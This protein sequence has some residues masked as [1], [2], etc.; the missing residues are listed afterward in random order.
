MGL[1]LS[2][3]SAACQSWIRRG[4]TRQTPGF[5]RLPARSTACG[6][7]HCSLKWALLQLPWHPGSLIKTCH[8]S[9][10][11]RVFV[12]WHPSTLVGLST[13]DLKGQFGGC[14]ATKALG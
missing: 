1:G 11:K 14:F 9:L 10:D 2:V 4:D 6:H 7:R 3:L 8:I 5:K 13:G 12:C